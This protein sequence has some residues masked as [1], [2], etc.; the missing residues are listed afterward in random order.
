MMFCEKI[1]LEAALPDTYYHGTSKEKAGQAILQSGYIEY[2]QEP[3]RKKTFM[4]PMVGRV[5]LT[6]N[7]PMA[8]IYGIG[9]SFIGHEYPKEWLDRI[10]EE[11]GIFGYVFQ[12]KQVDYDKV[13][14]DE[15]EVGRLIH[16]K[17]L[18]EL[19][20][21]AKPHLTSN[22]WYKVMDGEYAYWAAVGKKL[23]KIMPS[24][25]KALVMKHAKNVAHNGDMEIQHAWRFDKRLCKQFSKD[26]S[27]FFELAQQ[28]K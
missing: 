9:A 26:C 8:V 15:D 25:I 7:L 11:G 10:E 23:N 12:S 19:N 16:Y 20:N 1:L 4:H 2:V 5:Y 17:E 3:G 14:P 27:N 28:I 24:H 18:P 13:L 22:Q 6:K 21:W